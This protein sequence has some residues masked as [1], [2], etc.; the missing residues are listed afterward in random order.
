MKAEDLIVGATY[1]SLAE[2]GLVIVVDNVPE[3]T[4]GLVAV[5]YHPSSGKCSAKGVTPMA[6]PSHLL[7]VTKLMEELL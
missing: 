7:E 6:F 5:K 1:W 4:F 2:G 3:E